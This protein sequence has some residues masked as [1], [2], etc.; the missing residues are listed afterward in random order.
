MNYSVWPE[1]G[2]E[3]STPLVVAAR[4]LRSRSVDLLLKHGA[5]VDIG[6]PLHLFG[7]LDWQIFNRENFDSKEY[8]AV[9]AQLIRHGAVID[10]SLL[11][12]WRTVDNLLYAHGGI[13][14]AGEWFGTDLLRLILRENA[15]K[16]PQENSTVTVELISDADYD[17]IFHYYIMSLSTYLFELRFTLKVMEEILED[18]EKQEELDIADREL[19]ENIKEIKRPNLQRFCRISVRRALGSPLSLK[20]AK[21]NLPRTIE[22]YL[23]MLDV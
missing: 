1:Y 12:G 18:E 8:L 23:F 4:A 16:L 19:V 17:M 5:R 6:H 20:L 13:E 7:N 9:G 21:L 15:I 22:D 2:C 10:V 11:S 14:N 3:V